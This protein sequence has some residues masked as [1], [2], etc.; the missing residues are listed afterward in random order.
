MEMTT[1]IAMQHVV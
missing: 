1:V